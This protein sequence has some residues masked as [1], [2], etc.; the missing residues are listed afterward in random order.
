MG[1]WFL[2][3]RG[4]SHWTT[5]V[6]LGTLKNYVINAWA[7]FQIS[8]MRQKKCIHRDDN[9]VKNV[10]RSTEIWTKKKEEEE[11]VV[12][13]PPLVQLSTRGS[14]IDMVYV[15]ASQLGAFCP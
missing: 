4:P 14:H 1:Q 9:Y 15:K 11:V 13:T 3:L 2:F 10:T 5:R 8:C 6:F 7:D 12:S